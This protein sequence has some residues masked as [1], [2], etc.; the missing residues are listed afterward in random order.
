MIEVSEFDAIVEQNAVPL[1][2]ETICEQDVTLCSIGHDSDRWAIDLT[3]CADA[4]PKL[5]ID[6]IGMWL[7]QRVRLPNRHA[8]ILHQM[9]GVPHVPPGMGAEPPVHSSACEEFC[10]DPRGQQSKGLRRD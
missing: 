1:P 8:S 10:R 2:V 9:G 6:L 3:R 5:Q 7:R 4:V